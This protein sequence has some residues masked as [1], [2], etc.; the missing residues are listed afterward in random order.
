MPKQAAGKEV[1]IERDILT[2]SGSL[3]FGAI[4]VDQIN[5]LA[6]PAWSVC[7][8]SK[9]HRPDTPVGRGDTEVPAMKLSPIGEDDSGE[10]VSRDSESSD[11]EVNI[12]Q[13]VSSVI[14]QLAAESAE[15]QRVGVGNPGKSKRKGRG[16][17]RVAAQPPK[18][19]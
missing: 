13:K 8:K 14:A 12:L 9:E 2:T 17:G 18:P 3:L 15:Q 16:T 1:L 7:S 10:Y 19:V 5:L 6:T 4:K 11:L